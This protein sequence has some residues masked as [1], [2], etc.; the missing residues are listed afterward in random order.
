M[1]TDFNRC[2]IPDT[3]PGLT[4]PSFVF[5]ADASSKIGTGHVVRCLTLANEL[6][7]RGGECQFICREHHGH[8]IERIKND[9]FLV[10]VL[11]TTG[12][13][14]RDLLHSDWLGS[15]QRADAASSSCILENCQADWLIVDHYG[16]DYRWELEARQHV[17]QIMVIDDLADRKHDCDLLL[18]Q[19]YGSS[20]AL[21][22][23]SVPVECLQIHGPKYAL[24]KPSYAEHRKG[25]PSRDGQVRRA[26]IYFGGGEDRA[27]VTG[28]AVG[29]F[30]TPELE[31]VQLDIVVG[32][33]YAHQEALEN[34]VAQRTKKPKIHRQLR[35]L[36]ALMSV[37]DLAIGAGGS[38]MWERCC[39]GLPSIVICV[40]PNQ[41]RSCE[42]MHKAGFIRYLGEIDSVSKDIISSEITSVRARPND[43]RVLREKNSALV[44][45]CGSRLIADMLDSLTIH[46]KR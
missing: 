8:L 34:A 29:A 22:S 44:T 43:L 24:L 25:M 33:N 12:E 38:T 13:T 17:K 30:Q 15:T 6:R 7:K 26:M 46:E 42:E 3:K 19:N 21:Y 1:L 11:K 31:D 10:H 35:D 18:N 9:G 40:A 16:L 2:V 41:R 39:M 28:M 27:D 32:A 45:G 37:S 4:P 14:D 20:P 5:R 23:G 36:A